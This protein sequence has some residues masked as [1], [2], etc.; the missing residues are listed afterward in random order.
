MKKVLSLSLLTVFSL[1]FTP[2]T[3]KGPQWYVAHYENVLGTSME[4]KVAAP[5]PEAS[6]ETEKTVLKEI[7]RLSKILS[8]YDAQSEFSRWFRTNNLAVPISAELYEI[9]NLF[10]QWRLRTNG[11]L[12]ASAEALTQ[13]W[14]RAAKEQRLP[15]PSELAVAVETIKQPHW[16]LDPATHTAVHL[17]QVLL[18]LNSFAKSYII[19][20]A[21]IAARK[22]AGATSIV[23]NIGGDIV[24]DGK[25]T[26]PIDISDPKADAEN[27][28]ALD[29]IVIAN[30]AIATSGNYRR[31]E[32]IAG[33]WYSH[34]VDP[35]TG[36]PADR[37]LSATVVA[38]SATDAGALATAFNVL[39]ITECTA[40]ARQ[41]PGVEYLILTRDGQ[42]IQSPGWKALQANAAERTTPGIANAA[43]ST[44]PVAS[45][46]AANKNP[47]ANTTKAAPFE[48]VVNFEI[49]LQKEG[50]VKRP[51]IAIWVEDQDHAPVRTITVWHG[52]ERY[53]PEL[54]SWYLKYRSL[55]T[56]DP[57]FGTS[58]TSAT[59][60]AGKYSVKW[61]G[62]DDK[63]NEVKPGKYV[64]KIEVSRE[65]GTYQL[66]RQELDWNDQPQ[67][68]TLPANIEISAASLDYRK[69]PNGN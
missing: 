26:E 13:V 66:M 18:V 51:Y 49:N 57:N 28:P 43:E 69:K 54:R 15:I 38:P 30:A 59:R 37:V 17:D 10:D 12:D 52:S 65:H 64:I 31:G 58:I 19:Q 24:V 63:G 53:L 21:V 47:T 2:R 3:S 60:S 5:S 25:A 36:Q 68:L 14:K 44:T 20:H 61:D 11:A 27:D 41:Y 42:R 32:L 46:V 1:A 39:G 48:L 34:I 7:N 55:Y 29:H 4:L 8:G 23:L 45:N 6:Q 67:T 50:S 33:H 40:L 22:A 56:A 62:K 35:R 9:L 16:R